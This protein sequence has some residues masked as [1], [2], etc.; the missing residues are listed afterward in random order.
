MKLPI[1]SEKMTLDTTRV[2]SEIDIIRERQKTVVRE[3]A[4]LK[5]TDP[6]SR[7]K[8]TQDTDKLNSALNKYLDFMDRVRRK[9]THFSEKSFQTCLDSCTNN[10]IG[11]L[12]KDDALRGNIENIWADLKPQHMLN[13]LTQFAADWDTKLNRFV[14]CDTAT[15]E[16]MLELVEL[17]EE[18]LQ[19]KDITDEQ[20]LTIIHDALIKASQDPNIKNNVELMNDLNE[21]VRNLSHIAPQFNLQIP[22]ATHAAAPTTTPNPSKDD[23]QESPRP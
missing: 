16:K 14:E 9:E 7:R 17:I 2:Q 4:P 6:E 1:H 21:C 15:L 11:V 19:K 10:L 5:R 22:G 20:R 8:V 12:P 23:P 18:K 13:K 3:L